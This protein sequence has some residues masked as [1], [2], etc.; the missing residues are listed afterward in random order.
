[1]KKNCLILAIALCA[2][3]TGCSKKN[4]PET[5]DL[6]VR[7]VE[8]RLTG[9]GQWQ[10]CRPRK[11]RP[12]EVVHDAQCGTGT[13]NLAAN[14]STSSEESCE[15]MSI[16]SHTDANEVLSSHPRC[17][18]RVIAVLQAEKDPRAKSDLAAAYYVR[19]QF[20]DDPVDLLEALARAEEAVASNPRLPDAYFNRALA[21][22]ALGFR[23]D[24]IAS[25]EEFR[26]L[27]TNEEWRR[28]A[29]DRQNALTRDSAD[30][31]RQW[32][33][34]RRQVR[35]VA[36]TNPKLLA[37]W[38]R[39]YPTAA[40]RHI[41][42]DLLPDWANSGS[43]DAL[44]A[45]GAIAAELMSISGD[46]FSYD[47]VRSIERATAQQQ[48]LLAEG[49]R[50]YGLARQAGGNVGQI[51]N[52]AHC[53]SAMTAFEQG[54]S[55]FRHAAELLLCANQQDLAPVE[56]TLVMEETRHYASLRARAHYQLAYRRFMKNEL[57][58]SLAHYEQALAGYVELKD[59]ASQAATH[60]RL[61]G[62]LRT[63]GENKLSWR[64]VL[65]GQRGFNRVTGAAVRTTIVA[66][67]ATTA[68]AL[69]Y[70]RIAKRYRDAY[71]DSLRSELLVVADD[72]A[73]TDVLVM[74]LGIAL[75]GRAK[76]LTQIGDI[77][78]AR[79]DLE[80]SMRLAPAADIRD[81]MTRR[82]LETQSFE[83]EGRALLRSQP[84]RAI[85]KFTDAID[86][87]TAG[88][89]R[90]YRAL[91]LVRRAEANRLAGNSDAATADLRAALAELDREET[92]VLE[93]R[94][95]G[96]GEQFWGSYFS[97]FRE[98]YELLVK[99]YAGAGN[100]A[101]AFKY[102][103]RARAFELLT[104]IR[105]Q[106][107]AAAAF[108]AISESGKPLSLD[109]VSKALPVGTFVVEY[110]VL[111]D[112]TLVWVI[113]SGGVIPLRL[114]IPRRELDRWT[115]SLQ[116]AAQD[117]DDRAFAERLDAPYVGVIADAV[118]AIERLPGG[119]D[120]NRRIIFVPD[121][122][123][124]G[125]PF[126]ALRNPRTNRHL[127]ETAVVANAGSASLYVHSLLLDEQMPR[128]QPPSA[129]LVLDPAFDESL[130]LAKGRLAAA[131]GEAHSIGRYY[132]PHLDVLS[133]AGATVPRFLELAREHTVVHVSA[134][135]IPVA[136]APFASMLLLAAAE[137]DTG[138][139][140]SERL[141]R[142]LA[143]TKTRLVVLAACSS[144][145]GAPVGPEG[146]APLVR[147]LIAAGVPGVVGSLW[148]VR[149]DEASRLLASFHGHYKLGKDAAAALRDAQLDLLRDGSPRALAWAPFQ[150]IG[151]A[152]SPFGAPTKTNTQ[153]SH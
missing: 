45:A 144:A 152:S 28:E 24:A 64:E 122:A 88:S 23:A 136:R 128:V 132:R 73:Q 148:N 76:D 53:A 110:F 62:I 55:P 39:A 92:E 112:E 143:L 108:D 75:R 71:I 61:G 31:A 74:N 9:F 105:Q 69:G 140:N 95:R 99:H 78:Q 22:Q 35:D 2:F 51:A 101:E 43:K 10:Q 20:N 7:A 89:F 37:R 153:R 103:E 12:D 151:H 5:P 80:E 15:T 52:A 98:T 48:A 113:S 135:G 87:M 125:L 13:P 150:V 21:E 8:P 47:V 25:F 139:L 27:E 59:P 131:R 44:A 134:H 17:A 104:L 57:I 33:A 82:I 121:R 86:L 107:T 19:A 149:D 16:K 126:A 70:P 46:R 36:P 137:G 90:T 79:K 118:A 96:E 6:W 30:A 63:L 26:K 141:L 60:S 49:H 81:P 54:N 66:E 114:D 127:F 109:T 116:E 129:L 146:V 42:D 58:E 4:E 97:R 11:Q 91:L 124:H 40:Q 130:G 72:V 100:V 93:R 65:L 1:M 85:V 123:L 117:Q 32:P 115:T 77:A 133:D 34:V 94:K 145:G 102:A 38:V 111:D 84:T 106:E 18:D 50:R 138:V 3:A 119:K 29:R 68:V 147:P 14:V 83:A 56:R 67:T 41:E 120:P 142:E